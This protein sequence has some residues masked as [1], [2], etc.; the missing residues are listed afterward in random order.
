MNKTYINTVSVL[1]L[2]NFEV[3]LKSMR[4][5]L[6]S[7]STNWSTG[8]VV[9]YLKAQ[10]KAAY[11]IA[12]KEFGEQEGSAWAMVRNL[13]GKWVWGNY[14]TPNNVRLIGTYRSDEEA[15]FISNKVSKSVRLSEANKPTDFITQSVYNLTPQT[16]RPL[17][18]S[19][20]A[21][22]KKH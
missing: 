9:A 20:A 6:I 12:V 17:P 1:L 15:K 4:N 10:S 22:R 7:N 19:Q 3:T 13:E 11:A 21:T 14:L 8:K 18:R 2:G 16:V 5:S